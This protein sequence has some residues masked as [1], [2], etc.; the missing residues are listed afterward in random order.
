MPV[1][2]VSLAKVKVIVLALE[3]YREKEVSRA[4]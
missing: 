3:E 1:K 2:K 4:N